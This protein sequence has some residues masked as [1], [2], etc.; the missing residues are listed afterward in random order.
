MRTA[1]GSKILLDNGRYFERRDG[2]RSPVRSADRT[3]E[4][5]SA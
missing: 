5:C 1:A 3:G 2:A 4:R